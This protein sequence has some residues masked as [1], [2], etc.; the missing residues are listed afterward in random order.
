MKRF[1]SILLCLCLCGALFASIIS[2]AEAGPK[3]W[4]AVYDVFNTDGNFVGK[5]IVRVTGSQ[6]RIT[7]PNGQFTDGVITGELT[8]NVAAWG[9]AEGRCEPNGETC[10]RI[11]WSGGNQ[12][13]SG[14]QWQL[15]STEIPK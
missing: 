8:V 6:I 10:T 3:R 2:V 9:N 5:N 14:K 13:W 11:T 12:A 15:Y 1:F 4:E 7:H